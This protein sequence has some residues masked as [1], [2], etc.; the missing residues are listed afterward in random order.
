MIGDFRGNSVITSTQSSANGTRLAN[1][2]SSS[3]VQPGGSLIWDHTSPTTIWVSTGSA[4]VALA[5]GSGTVSSISQGAGIT[6]TPN[7]IV[8]IGTVA[9]TNTTVAAASYKIT[10]LTVNAR[11][12]LTAASSASPGTSTLNAVVRWGN[13]SA[14]GLL[15]SGVIV[16]NSNNVTGVN[17]IAVVQ[18]TNQIVLGTTN[19][20]TLNATAPAASRVYTLPDAGA[21]AN[22]VLDSGGAMTITDAPSAGEILVATGATTANWAPLP[23]AFT[24]QD[25]SVAGGTATSPTVS[26][27]TTFI[28]TTG[29]GTATGTLGDGT[30]NGQFKYLVAVSITAG[31]NYDLASTAGNVID[32]NGAAVTT[33]RFSTS[34]NALTLI[35]NTTT[36]KWFIVGAGATLL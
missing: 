33:M 28:T 23:G 15:D 36:S 22:V 19:T 13:I 27:T 26:I 3:A 5:A 31:V 2:S 21:N 34:G 30:S 20:T 10:N 17:T 24:A 8:G 7:P 11:G 18:T 16:D 4:W 32:A 1:I 14:D 9:I 6:C 12:Q 35:W 25:I 29:A